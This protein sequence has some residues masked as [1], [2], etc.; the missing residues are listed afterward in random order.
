MKKAL[1]ICLSLLFLCAFIGCDNTDY[2]DSE[3]S[4]VS[5]TTT[6]ND[7]IINSVNETTTKQ[8]AEK[9]NSQIIAPPNSIME[10][11]VKFYVI[12]QMNN[13]NLEYSSVLGNNIPT[14]ATLSSNGAMISEITSFNSKFG[15]SISDFFGTNGQWKKLDSGEYSYSF[16]GTGQDEHGNY[17]ELIIM[18][19]PDYCNSN[20]FSAAYIIKSNMRDMYG[21]DLYYN[22]YDIELLSYIFKGEKQSYNN[23]EATITTTEPQ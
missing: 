19:V 2:T 15:K 5:V 7:S 16:Q 18:L 8:V 23:Q 9:T 3:E 10:S 21:N 17:F 11:D 4:S 13:G 22:P 1:C 14:D 20:M 12:T 6:K